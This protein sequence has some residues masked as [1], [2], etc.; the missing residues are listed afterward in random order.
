MQL[1]NKRGGMFG[2]KN[3]PINANFKKKILFQTLHQHK[4]NEQTN[5]IKISNAAEVSESIRLT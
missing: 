4:T 1:A 2:P 5:K 3:N